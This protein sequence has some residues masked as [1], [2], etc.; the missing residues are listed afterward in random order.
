MEFSAICNLEL[1]FSKIHFHNVHFG[2]ASACKFSAYVLYVFC[3]G[4][5]SINEFVIIYLFYAECNQALLWY[6]VSVTSA[7]YITHVIYDNNYHI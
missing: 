5:I 6:M 4:M 7:L 1:N 3:G 2:H